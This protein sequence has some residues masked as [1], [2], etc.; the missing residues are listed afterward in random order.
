MTEADFVFKIVVVGDS[1]VGKTCLLNRFA[2][3]QFVELSHS[4]IGIDFKIK[5]VQVSGRAFKLQ[6]VRTNQWDTAGQERF[7]NITAAYF[8]GA[9]GVV[10]LYDVSQRETF[11]SVTSWVNEVDTYSPN[12]PKILLAAKSDVDN[13][14]VSAVEGQTLA[15]SL[16]LEFFEVS[17]KTDI[18][19]H[20]AFQ[21]F[22]RAI[23]ARTPEAVVEH[24][25][26]PKAK[27]KRKKSCC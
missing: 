26:L 16:G 8:R 21:S 14:C 23:Y 25:K 7:R 4:T 1:G 17:S 6:I 18:N 11:D 5:I 22:T 24:S 27:P 3:G 2:D 13:P 20:E 9:N 12:A 10:V 15:E 19:V